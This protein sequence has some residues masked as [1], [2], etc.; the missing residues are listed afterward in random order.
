[1]RFLHTSDWHLGMNF[2]GLE[3]EED[4]EFFIRQIC[5]MM[6]AEKVDAMILAGDVFDRSV[7]PASALAL[8]DRT[9]TYICGQLQIPVF[10]VAGN[11]DGARRLA[12]CHELLKKAGL[13][14]AGELTRPV[15]PV[16][17]G[18]TDVYLLP[19][20]TLEK[21][22]ALYPERAEE[23]STL[24]DAYELVCEEMRAGFK[25]G[26]KHIL[27]AHAF[28]VNAETSVSDRAAEVGMATAV[29]ANVF[30]DFDYVAL[31]HIHGPQDITDSIRYSGTPMPYSFGKEEKQVK[32]VTII[33]TSVMKKDVRPLGLLHE[34]TTLRG[35]LEELLRP[36]ELQVTEG[37]R[38]GYVRL[39]VTDHYVGMEAFAALQEVYPHLLEAAGVNFEQGDTGITMSLE[40]LAAKETD[41]LEIFKQYFRDTNGE[42]PSGHFE[43]LF[44]EAV[45]DYEKEV[46]G[47]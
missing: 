41:P 9:M 34:R 11:H 4:Q 37:Q 13:Y 19:W 3:I 38:K 6:V 8:Y 44:L 14:I 1:M 40:E 27:A 30:R 25:P 36:E 2:R 35:T 23:L 20:F 18:D 15:E 32:S 31:G 33:D 42:E 5:E 46:Q 22:R 7:S 24:E 26:R 21:V 16:E 29:N 10:V 12:S 17:M 28:I 39:E 45:K 47:E 43:E